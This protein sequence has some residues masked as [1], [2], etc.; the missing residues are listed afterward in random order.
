[1]SRGALSVG[2]GGGG[3]GRRVVED[4]S[5]GVVNKLGDFN[6]VRGSEKIRL[7]SAK[8]LRSKVLEG[9]VGT[10]NRDI[11]L[12]NVDALIEALSASMKETDRVAAQQN[13]GGAQSLVYLKSI[14]EKVG[15]IS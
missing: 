11:S 8:R 3:T 10:R 14:S 13:K 7:D 4:K 9:G 12:K 6:I 15:G 1:M 5:K 2:I